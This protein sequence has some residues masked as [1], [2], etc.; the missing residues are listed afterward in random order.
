MRDKESS[1]RGRSFDR[2]SRG[3]R[4]GRGGDRGSRGDRGRGNY[5]RGCNFKLLI[6]KARGNR[7]GRT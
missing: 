5:E 2:G 1:S 3:D 6:N 4:G 7:R